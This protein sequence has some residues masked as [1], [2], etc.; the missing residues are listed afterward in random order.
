MNFKEDILNSYGNITEDK[1]N[2]NNFYDFDYS[3]E[4][5]KSNQYINSQKKYCFLTML[6]QLFNASYR[7]V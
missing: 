1:Q 3:S 6:K 4:V 2:Y 5:R 7:G